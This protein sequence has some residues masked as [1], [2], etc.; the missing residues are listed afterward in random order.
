[1]RRLVEEDAAAYTKVSEAYRLPKDTSHRS[2]AIDA[3]LLGAAAVPLDGARKA[4]ALHDLAREIGTIGNKNAVSDAM[5]A[6]TLAAA[7]LVGLA[8][9]VRVNVESLSDKTLG[10]QLGQEAGALRQRV[11]A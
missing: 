9:N 3:A 10:A 7:A 1:L 5:V 6:R 4:L 11:N 8:E 2:Q